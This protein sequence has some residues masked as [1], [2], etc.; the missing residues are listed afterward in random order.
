MLCDE[1]IAAGFSSITLGQPDGWLWEGQA[2]AD[3]DGGVPAAIVWT[4]DGR[5]LL[6]ANEPV[7]LTLVV[8]LAKD[9]RLLDRDLTAGRQEID[10]RLAAGATRVQA[11]IVSAELRR[12]QQLPD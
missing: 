11:P 12:S 10:V 8:E 4:A 7:E 1:L 2:V 5:V 6:Y 9:V 3:G